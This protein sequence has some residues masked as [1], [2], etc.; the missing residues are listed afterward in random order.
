VSRRSA[1]ECLDVRT[2]YAS[3]A[4][5]TRLYHQGYEPS[6]LHQEQLPVPC[7]NEG[8]SGPS[9]D[10]H[11]ERREGYPLDGTDVLYLRHTGVEGRGH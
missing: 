1:Q 11:L 3:F 10:A 7:D 2:T 5:G 6:P 9:Y 8:A 4:S